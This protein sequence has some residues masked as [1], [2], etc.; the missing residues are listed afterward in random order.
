MRGRSEH[1]NLERLDRVAKVLKVERRW[2]MHGL[3][4]VEARCRS[5]KAPSERRRQRGRADQ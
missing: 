1:P 2:L 4:D 3:G 5:W